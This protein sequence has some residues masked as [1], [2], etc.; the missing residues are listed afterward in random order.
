MRAIVWS[1]STG[2]GKTVHLA[3]DF[4][5]GESPPSGRLAVYPVSED[6]R[7]AQSLSSEVNIRESRENGKPEVLAQRRKRDA[8]MPIWHAFQDGRDEHTW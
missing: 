6:V 3:V 2:I 4:D 8:G 7:G 1:S 5:R